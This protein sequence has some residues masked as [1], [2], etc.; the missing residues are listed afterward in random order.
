MNGVVRPLDNGLYDDFRRVDEWLQIVEALASS[1]ERADLLEKK[2]FLIDVRTW[3]T[4]CVRAAL[5]EKDAS[6]CAA[7][8]R[9]SFDALGLSDGRWYDTPF[10]SNWTTQETALHP[11]VFPLDHQ[12]DWDWL[13]SSSV[14]I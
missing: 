8:A 4:S 7:Q 10:Q 12:S 6:D 5:A 14:I 2:Q 3:A 13:H 9:A 11:D 1:S